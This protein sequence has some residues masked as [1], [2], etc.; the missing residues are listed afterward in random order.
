MLRVLCPRVA[1]QRSYV[2][3]HIRTLEVCAFRRLA[4]PGG[5]RLVLLIGRGGDASRNSTGFPGALFVPAGHMRANSAVLDRSRGGG[6][7]KKS[8]VK[9]FCPNHEVHRF[10]VGEPSRPQIP[11]W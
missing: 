8:P 9:K 2:K 10:E 1:F 7:G 4:E 6:S 5:R 3:D 11:H